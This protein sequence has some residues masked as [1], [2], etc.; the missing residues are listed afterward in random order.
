MSDNAIR[1]GIIG[2][3][4]RASWAQFS[5]IPAIQHLD[6]VT[7]SAVA[8]R[9]EDSAREA[10]A[11]FGAPKWFADPFAMIR[12]DS[13][14]VV[15]VAVRVPAH[16]DLVRAAIEAGKAV[17][18]EAPRGASLEATREL[19]ASAGTGHTAI[20]LQGRLNP[21]V[22]R[23]AQ[24]IAEGRIGRPLSARVVSTSSG[25]GPV[26]ASPYEYFERAASGAN[27][28]TITTGHTLDIIEALL[29]DITEVDARTEIFWPHPTLADTGA[30][31][32]RE[33]PDH[34]GVLAKVATGTVIAADII[35]G[36]APEEAAFRFGLR[37]SDGWLNLTGG[38]LFGVQ[39]GDL[40]L[41]SSADFD[42]PD[43]PAAPGTAGPA[44]NVGELYA[45]LARDIRTGSYSVPG[46]AEALHNSRLIDAVA[47]AASSGHRVTGIH[48][49]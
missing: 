47:V 21:S 11:A 36:V 7:L 35:G 30:T 26:T 40:T 16:R 19:A 29:G 34:A 10:A 28:L 31:T 43:K 9:R 23:A 1:V 14:D 8:T 13:V 5:H 39:G 27:L 20:G 4:T 46:F 33:V 32:T 49:R 48:Q 38:T 15:T 41:S 45:L 25:F 12:D 2:A 17:Y 22:R 24:I 37:G 42:E 18:C 6:A 44:L 3:D